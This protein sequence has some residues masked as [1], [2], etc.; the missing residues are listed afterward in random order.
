MAGELSTPNHRVVGRRT[1]RPM[2]I[3]A[4]AYSCLL[5]V[6][7]RTLGELERA[8]GAAGRTEHPCSARCSHYASALPSRCDE[9]DPTFLC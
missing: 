1:C 3:D 6:S 7:A 4:R 9:W 5:R 2:P 8:H